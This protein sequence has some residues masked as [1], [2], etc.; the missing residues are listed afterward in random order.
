MNYIA[1]IY[2]YSDAEFESMFEGIDGR[3]KILKKRNL[4]KQL[5]EKFESKFEVTRHPFTSF[6]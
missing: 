2:A 3:V 5:L 6:E 1:S 4:V